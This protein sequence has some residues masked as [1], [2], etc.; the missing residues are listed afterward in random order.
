M[1]RRQS[2]GSKVGAIAGVVILIAFFLPWVRACGEDLS[3]Y[4]LATDQ[5]GS[6]EDA[7]MYWVTPLAGL[8][9]VALCFLVKTDRARSRIGA[10]VSR[11]IVGLIGF[12]PVLNV[13]YNVK[14]SETTM[15]ILYGGWITALGYLGILVSFFIDLG[16]SADKDETEHIEVKQ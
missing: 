16:G 15:E 7:W 14:K 9:C 6:V 10:A 12:I 8:F 1:S 5:T 4:D 13:W 3:G 11:L 2:I